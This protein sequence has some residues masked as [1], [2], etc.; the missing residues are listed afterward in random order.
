MKQQYIN[1]SGF[2]QERKNIFNFRNSKSS[3][4]WRTHAHFLLAIDTQS[5]LRNLQVVSEVSV[6]SKIL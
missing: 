1:I 5:V 4:R 3:E 6:W 2:R